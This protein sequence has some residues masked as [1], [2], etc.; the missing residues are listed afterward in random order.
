MNKVMR[1]VIAVAAVLGALGTTRPTRGDDMAFVS[2]PFRLDMRMENGKRVADA[3]EIIQTSAAWA[4]GS[5][6][7]VAKV[8]HTPPGGEAETLHTT[9]S[10][11]TESFAWDALHSVTGDHVFVHTVWRGGVQVDTMSV[12]FTVPDP[13]LNAIRIFGPT[14]FYS[15][16]TAQYTC[17]GYF[18]DD[19]GRQVLPT[20]SLV[21]PVAGV[22]VDQNGVLSADESST[23]K[24]VTLRAVATVGDRVA[25]NELAVTVKAAY[26]SFGQQRPRLQLESSASEASVR[27]NCSGVWTA[28]SSADWLVVSNGSGTGDGLFVL[29][30]GKNPS[31]DDRSATVTVRCGTLTQTMRVMQ[32]GGEP[33]TRV[34]VAFDAQGGTATYGSHE[35]VV[36]E[37]YGTLPYAT[38]T[39]KVFGGWWT[40]TNG[41]GSRMLASSEATIGVTV[42][43]AYWRDMTSAD[44][45]DNALDW[46]DD[47]D[48]DWVIDESES[49]VGGSSMRSG[50]VGRM[51]ASTI[52]T[53]VTGPGTISFWWRT[54][55]SEDDCLVFFDNGNYIQDY[56]IYGETG[57]LHQEYTI[58]DEGTHYLSWSYEKYTRT[59]EG[60]DCGWIDGVVWTP[61]YT[62][63]ETNN[64]GVGIESLQESHIPPVAWRL[65]YGL[66]GEGPADDD[67]DGDG[68]TDYEE[69]VVGS[70]PIDPASKFTLSIEMD[71]DTPVLEPSPYL[72]EG[73]RTY[74]IEGKTN[75]TDPNWAPADY[76]R[77][78]F[79][80]AKVELK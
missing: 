63:S 42:L 60:R 71:G 65:A 64:T 47:G 59:G 10:A 9:T 46:M 16:N 49:K 70:N 40:Q 24:S 68:L 33:E 67:S 5:G 22:S 53:E 26:L 62:V 56:E 43:Y 80:R 1:N 74:T 79:F 77:H 75:L 78:R 41:R 12:T 38:K 31:T 32:Y 55:C 2:A 73:Q 14:N 7:A 36:G 11:G 21:T 45:L 66:N 50:V 18:S 44:A 13:V 35:Y 48:A 51:Q 52:F 39:G 4:G 54:S 17:M 23:A 76:T 34:T 3:V 29:S 6:E 8:R 57:W 15:G 37:K 69:Y 20:W 27:V 61:N 28:E 19:S 30:C 72:G 58:M 25:T